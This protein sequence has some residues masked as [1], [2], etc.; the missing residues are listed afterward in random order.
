MVPDRTR[1]TAFKMTLMEGT[2][3]TVVKVVR[4]KASRAAADWVCP[5]RENRN[6]IPNMAVDP[7]VHELVGLLSVSGEVAAIQI[8]EDVAASDTERTANPAHAFEPIQSFLSALNAALRAGV[9]SSISLTTDGEWIASNGRDDYTL[10]YKLSES[11]RGVYDLEFHVTGDFTRVEFENHSFEIN[12]LAAI[13]SALKQW[14][15]SK[16]KG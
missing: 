10:L 3:P 5:I 14:V 11:S 12:D 4:G 16:L 2:I 15:V 13:E 8:D 7:K 9:D 6:N 1:L